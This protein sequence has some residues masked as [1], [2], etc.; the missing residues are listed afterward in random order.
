MMV[1]GT[2]HN[3]VIGNYVGTDISGAADLGNHGHGISME[4]AA[5]ANLIQGN[6]SSGNGRAGICISDRGSDYNIASGNRV[7]TDASGMQAIPNDW[8]GVFVGFGGSSF[9]RIGGTAPS[10]GNLISGNAMGLSISDPNAAGNL[11]LGNLIGVDASGLAGLGNVQQGLDISASETY[12]EA[13]VIDANGGDG[14]RMVAGSTS[15]FVLGN[16][17]GTGSNG[18]TPLG[19]GRVGIMILAPRNFIQA[20]LVA[21][22]ISHGVQVEDS[23]HNIIRQNSI[24]SNGGDGIVLV[25][26]GNARLAAPMLTVDPVDGISGTACAGCTVELFADDGDEGRYW[27]DSQV[28]NGVGSF[29]FGR[30]CTSAGLSFTST[31]TDNAGNT[32]EFSPP[33]AM[34]W[35]CDYIYLPVLL[36]LPP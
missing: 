34:Q 6:L 1:A 26:D 35:T 3:Q 14:V 20:N 2:S 28:T 32:S 30:L 10:E 5:S 7:G 18:I 24:F 13:N 21:F 27:L 25:G 4:L 19:N 12:A 31:V 23:Q 11:V 15:S 33:Q 17:I 29:A 9:N 8:V 22:N 16:R 36:R